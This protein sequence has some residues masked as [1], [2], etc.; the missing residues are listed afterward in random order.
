MKIYYGIKKMIK[1]LLKIIKQ[2]GLLGFFSIL[3]DRIFLL[4]GLQV[5]LKKYQG[6]KISIKRKI[7]GS[8]GLSFDERGFWHVNPMPSKESLDE[9]YSSSYW[10][11]RH[12]KKEIITGRDVIH[13]LILDKFIPNLHNSSI[14]F[15]NFGAGHGGISHLMWLNG[16]NIFNVEPS[17]IG[18]FYEERWTH[19]SSIVE[20]PDNSLDFIYGSHS[21]EHVHDIDNMNKEVAKKLKKGGYIFWEVPN[22]EYPGCGP[23]ENEIRIPHTYYFTKKYFSNNY[24]NIILNEAFQQT[25]QIQKYTDWE[26]YQKPSDD[27]EVI[28]VLVKNS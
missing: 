14:N 4:F 25:H 13:L 28:R 7:F 21:L 17:G 27:G 26:K 1:K 8:R 19:L 15:L 20:A 16:H 5:L 11:Y 6:P 22:G 18:K 23:L 9:Y 3:F 24:K 12:D 10:E 2:D